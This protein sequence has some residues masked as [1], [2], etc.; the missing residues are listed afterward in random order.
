MNYIEETFQSLSTKYSERTLWCLGMWLSHLVTWYSF[1]VFLFIMYYFNL[2]P[3]YKIQPTK[4]PKRELVISCL[5][6]TLL[7]HFV[8]QP[9]LVYFMLYPFFNYVSTTDI[10]APFPSL[11]RII[12]ELIGCFLLMDF[13][14]YWVHRWVHETPKVY[15]FVHKKHHMFHANIGIAA[16]YATLTEDV[17]LNYSSVFIGLILI[18][19]HP[20]V[21]F[22]FIA[23]RMTESIEVHSGYDLPWFL[24]NK[25]PA[26]EGAKW[27]EFHHSANM[28]NYGIFTFWDRWMG[29]DKQYRKKYAK[30]P[31]GKSA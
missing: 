22:L 11:L 4:K 6:H 2:F 21:Q 14:F 30:E 10:T 29:T 5:Q 12:S 8:S 23:I 31:A 3:Q 19:S 28:G 16:E 18:A 20:I 27:H 26:H 1:Q 13:Q 24:W 7:S 15:A 9:F 25:L 17:L